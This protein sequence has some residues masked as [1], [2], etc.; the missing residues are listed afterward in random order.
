MTVILGTIIVIAAVLGGYMGGGGHVGVLW[1]PFEFVIILGAGIG[2]TITANSK[3]SLKSLGGSV[4]RMIKGPSYKKEDFL[5]V[6]CLQYQIFKLAKTKGMLALEAHVE[7]P[8]ESTLFS[9]FP[10]FH[11]DHHAVAFV[12]DYLRMMSLGA[13]VPHE[14][15]ALMD[16]ELEVHHMEEHNVEAALAGLG[17]G[18]PALGIVA[19]VLGVIHTM[20]SISEPPEILGKL[21][22]AALVGTFFGILMSYGFVAPMASAYSKVTEEDSRY[23]ECLKAGILAH[24]AGNAPTVSVEYARKTLMSHV[25]P[26]FYELEE[27]ANELPAPG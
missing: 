10:K 9:Q 8:E 7:N 11:G 14:V 17:E 6:L 15:E 27:A 21:I 25:R 12:C 19:A 1:Q 13:D 3:V 5:E 24:M 22:G 16:Q 2:A 18:L 23:Y 20:G 26:S 4:G